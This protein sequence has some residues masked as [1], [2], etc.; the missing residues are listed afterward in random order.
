MSIY[1][2][3]DEQ[4]LFESLKNFPYSKDDW[5]KLPL[6]AS[7]NDFGGFSGRTHTEETKERMRQAHTG[8]VVSE[9]TREK[10]SKAAIGRPQTPGRSAALAK[11]NERPRSAESNAK[12]SAALKG[13]P[14]QRHTCPYCGTSGSAGN[15]TRWHGINCKSYIQPDPCSPSDC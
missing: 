4:Q 10:L 5:D 11:L 14:L 2:T 12:R 8:R 15:I 13:I 1:L 7:W 6:V 3:Q 9:A